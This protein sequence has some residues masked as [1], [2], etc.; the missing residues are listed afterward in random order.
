VKEHVAVKMH[1]EE[2]EVEDVDWIHLTQKGT[3]ATSC[4]QPSGS[5]RKD[6]RIS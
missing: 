5:I 1:F 4:E 3:V 2:T 6:G